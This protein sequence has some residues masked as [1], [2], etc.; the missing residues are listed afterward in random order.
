MDKF[1]LTL[2]R[3]ATVLAVLAV[4]AAQASINRVWVS[5]HGVDGP[6]CGAVTSPCRQIK[7]ALDNNIVSPGGEIDILDPS[8]F[9]PFTMAYA[10][11]IVNDGVGT[12]SIQQGAVGQNAITITAGPTDVIH[13]RGLSLE[14]LGTANAG[15]FLN[16]AGNV[17]IINCVARHFNNA[18]MWFQPSASNPPLIQTPIVTLSNVIA[19]DNGQY[20]IIFY[21][22]NF[23]LLLGSVSQSTVLNNGSAGIMS[24]TDNGGSVGTWISNSYIS[25][26][27]FGTNVTQYGGIAAYGSSP[28]IYLTG[29][30]V[31]NNNNHD[32][33]LSG[34]A[35][36]ATIYS[37]ANNAL[38]GSNYQ[39]SKGF[40]LQ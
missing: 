39:L 8:G 17:T 33:S 10:V 32:L 13:L 2:F 35:T 36:V 40:N 16:S 9:A 21:P 30:V 3:A 6:S 5:A 4:Q 11:S 7:Y 34:G 31:I 20:G 12:A 38:G 19:A 27:S 24:S 15:I 26:N 29:N 25:G 22:R 37:Y 14:G 23:V 28:S 18:G 1:Q